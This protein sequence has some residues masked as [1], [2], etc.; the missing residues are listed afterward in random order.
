MATQQ[1]KNILTYLHDCYQADHRDE[2]ILDVFNPKLPFRQ[3]IEKK[4]VLFNDL[5]PRVSLADPRLEEINK[6]AALQQREKRLCTG[7]LFCTG[8]FLVE[9]IEQRICSPLWI[10][11]AA[12]DTEG[13]T[14]GISTVLEEVKPNYHLISTLVS[15]TGEEVTVDGVLAKIP[16]L[17][18][19]DRKLQQLTRELDRAFPFMN[20]EPMADYPEQ[21]PESKIKPQMRKPRKG[22][23]GDFIRL[24]LLPATALL[25][26]NRSV[27]TRGVLHE[28]DLLKN[29]SPLSEP[30]QVLFSQ[31]VPPQSPGPNLGK[32]HVPAILNKPQRKVLD[33]AS[34]KTLSQVTG[35]P[36]TGKS[37]TI[38]AVALDHLERG[39]SVLIVSKTNQAVDVVADKI[40]AILGIKHFVIRGGRKQYKKDLKLFIE[41]LLNGI[42]PFNV[43]QVYNTSEHRYLQARIEE[44]EKLL[45]QRT[46]RE[47]QWG[48][49]DS[50]DPGGFFTRIM[51][52]L[53][54]R[55]LDRKL[56]RE[57]PYWDLLH[58]YY[59]CIMR[60][61]ELQKEMLQRSINERLTGLN[62]KH[63]DA[64]RHFSKAVKAQRSSRQ[65]EHMSQIDFRRIFSIF[66]I[67]MVN[68]TDVCRVLPLAR[69]QFDV[70]LIDEATQ[71][72]MAA[73]LPAL[74]RAKRAVIMGDPHQ[75][76]HISF[77][78]RSRQAEIARRAGLTDRE[79]A[80]FN[81][82]DDSIL[83]LVRDRISEQEDVVFLDEH[84]RSLPPLIRF[85]NREF[86]NGA[87]KIM[88]ERPKPVE[89]QCMFYLNVGGSREEAGHNPT[90]A[91]RIID[92]LNRIANEQAGRPPEQCNSLGILSPFS[93]QV[94]HLSK[95]IAAKVPMTMIQRHK[96]LTGTP[97]AFQ[98]EERDMML[99][100]L[101]LDPASH[102]GAFQYLERKDVFNVAI[103]RARNLQVFYGSFGT[104]E[105]KVKPLLSRFLQFVEHEKDSVPDSTDP[106]GDPFLAEVLEALSS[107]G[108]HC[109]PNFPVAGFHVDLVVEN[110]GVMLGID[111][112]GYPGIYSDAF[113]LE[114]Y[115]LF[116]RA[117]LSI[118]PLTYHGWRR[119]RRA[120]LDALEAWLK[121]K[122]VDV[123]GKEV[124]TTQ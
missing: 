83:D 19:T 23:K 81:Y 49:F 119:D 79:T 20:L 6:E 44:L 64:L 88:Q 37:F 108:W 48:A 57:A 60:N 2:E 11:P 107:G 94:E 33:N 87:I 56:D 123:P 61:L 39:E 1:A 80:L 109:W 75:L 32:H 58:E 98:G 76:R 34:Y 102:P 35:P 103:T 25:M 4:D 69:E 27:N 92:K 3:F 45:P 111:L 7:F 120:C 18:L 73:C 89:E 46:L 26:V 30:L 110:G 105:T 104:A 100:S 40:E 66:P 90:E 38:A 50:Q 118:F 112:I 121:T 72:D 53:K 21:Y 74:H 106:S 13:I 15:L 101:V 42:V 62:R 12:I 54:H 95:E 29:A 16:P 22:K 99:I 28:L 91:E 36:G 55:N 24:S 117:G 47:Q 96:I 71:C 41:N 65:E 85:S 97:Y 31:K 78:S 10:G 68:V 70:V 115:R 5:L 9:G 113:E 51:H 59:Y 8:R 82:R 63:R 122:G 77:L 84:F 52:R 93:A 86:Y 67:W 14:P 17:P 124:V 114:R 116:N 43:T